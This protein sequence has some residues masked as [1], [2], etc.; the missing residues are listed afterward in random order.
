MIFVI[1]ARLQILS[2]N[3]TKRERYETVTEYVNS[4][5]MFKR[6]HNSKLLIYIPFIFEIHFILYEIYSILPFS[7]AYTEKNF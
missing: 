2:G 4:K 5:R 7:D 3:V 1:F 6:H